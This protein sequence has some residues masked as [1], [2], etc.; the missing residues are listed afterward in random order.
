MAN[1][2]VNFVLQDYGLQN[3]K[4][5]ES[6]VLIFDQVRHLDHPRSIP[7]EQLA[8]SDLLDMQ[9][10]ILD[11]TEAINVQV[12]DLH[13]LSFKSQLK[14]VRQ[15]DI[16]M[17]YQQQGYYEGSQLAHA[18]SLQDGATFIELQN[19][20]T[21]MQNIARW[22]PAI[23]YCSIYSSSMKII[24]CQ[25]VPNVKDGV[26]TPDWDTDTRRY[27]DEYYEDEDSMYNETDTSLTD[28]IID[29]ER[30]DEE[31]DPTSQNL[32][33]GWNAFLNVYDEHDCELLYSR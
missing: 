6:N 27:P 15:A 13:N 19:S 29:G 16:M 28:D 1:A 23:K 24:D 30:F 2:F 25:I 21:Q 18:M 26:L 31:E 5:Q 14:L 12:V 9:A 22:R 32:L 20:G 17:G 33:T 7:E 10:K 11:K 3:I 4:K 8:N